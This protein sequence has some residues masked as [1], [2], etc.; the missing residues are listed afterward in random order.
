MAD[1]EKTTCDCTIG[2]QPGFYDMVNEMLSINMSAN[3]I[4][5]EAK[6]KGR[7]IK[8]ETVQRHLAVC[9]NGRRPRPNP[10]AVATV[11]KNPHAPKIERDLAKLV[12][13]AT[14]LIDKRE[15]REEDKRFMLGLARLLSGAGG[16]G[17]VDPTVIDVTPVN[18]LLAPPHLRADSGD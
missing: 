1:T 12:L 16:S 13:A 3:A 14:A 17:P 9:L 18:P 11:A 5:R 4:E 8:R 15:A 2:K 7:A 10:L 6:A